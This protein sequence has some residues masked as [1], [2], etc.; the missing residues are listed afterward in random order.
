M[1][2]AEEAGDAGLGE[3][4]DD[5]AA[6]AAV[7]EKRSNIQ[8]RL[9][10]RRLIAKRRIERVV[11]D[12][13]KILVEQRLMYE[14]T[15]PES[16]TAAAPTPRAALDPEVAAEELRLAREALT[17][18]VDALVVLFRRVRAAE[19]QVSPNSLDCPAVLAFAVSAPGT[20]WYC[21]DWRRTPVPLFAE[22]MKKLFLAAFT[23][24]NET[25]NR[26]KKTKFNKK[27]PRPEDE[28]P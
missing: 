16:V 27:R 22:S 24:E 13:H 23:N 14:E 5:D 28:E 25:E 12:M 6:E 10:M 11:R 19:K 26:L 15:H 8:S 21:E 2:D 20:S 1:D 7:P 17:Q 9:G 4:N 3:A 18:G